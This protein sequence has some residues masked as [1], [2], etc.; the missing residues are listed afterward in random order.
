MNEENKVEL[1]KKLQE[2]ENVEEVENNVNVEEPKEDEPEKDSEEYYDDI[3]YQQ[4]EETEKVKEK[5]RSVLR[6]AIDWVICFVIAY[7]IYLNINYFLISAPGVRQESMYPTVMSGERV[8]VIRPWLAGDFEYGDI[9][10]FEAPID[11]KLYL[12][13]AEAFPTAQYENYTGLTLFLYKFLDVNK[14]TYI[15]RVIGLPGDHIEIKDGNVYRNGEM[16]NEPYIRE[17]LTE[18]QQEEYSDVVVPEDTVY[19][20][21]DNR[22]S[23]MDSR[24]FGCIPYDRVNG[25]VVCRLWPLNKLGAIDK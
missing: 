18:D 17:P 19:V 4:K 21:G 23:S 15:K 25:K 13:S 5:T 11:N 8:L 1:E 2:T 9:V 10:T 16:L 3:N 7:V 22:G 24:T 12:D 20:M 6:E 14:T